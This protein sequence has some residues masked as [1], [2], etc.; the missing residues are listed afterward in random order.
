MLGLTSICAMP[1]SRS[2]I[3]P[4]PSQLAFFH[5]RADDKPAI[6]LHL[7]RNVMRPQDQT[8]VFVATKHH[9]E[10]LKEAS[11]AWGRRCITGLVLAP[12]Y[13][14]GAVGLGQALVCCE[15]T[16]GA[17]GMKQKRSLPC[18]EGGAVA[19]VAF[20]ARAAWVTLPQWSSIEGPMGTRT[21]TW[22][23]SRALGL[24]RCLRKQLCMVAL[25]LLFEALPLC[26]TRGQHL[27][28]TGN[29]SQEGTFWAMGTSPLFTGT[30]EQLQC[31][32]EACKTR[33]LKYMGLTE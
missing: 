13:K 30:P 28:G 33:G 6:L 9:T 22:Q 24:G 16:P 11:A 14:L 1:C 7:L 21:S 19:G 8:V 3:P 25:V 20:P 10:Y 23:C 31:L 27:T 4:L 5:V 32:G 15:G 12:L 26:A 18:P 29:R 2:L 17:A